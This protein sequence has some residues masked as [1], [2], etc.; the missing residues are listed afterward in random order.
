MIVGRMAF[1]TSFGILSSPGALP[2]FSR[3]TAFQIS[4]V[5]IRGHASSGG[6]ALVPS[7]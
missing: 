1:R 2:D 6:Y 3:L 7:V 4:I 5:V